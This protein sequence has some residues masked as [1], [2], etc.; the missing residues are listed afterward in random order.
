[1]N[2]LNTGQVEK[3][4]LEY[5][6]LEIEMDWNSACLRASIGASHPSLVPNL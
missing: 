2:W 4:A 3:S 5:P 6:V 1:M